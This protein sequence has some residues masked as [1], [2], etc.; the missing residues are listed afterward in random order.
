MT[1]LFSIFL[2]SPGC[3]YSISALNLWLL[4]LTRV[5]RTETKS[6]TKSDFHIFIFLRVMPFIYISGNKLFFFSRKFSNVFL[7]QQYMIKSYVFSHKL[8]ILLLSY[9]WIQ[10]MCVALPRVSKFGFSPCCQ[11]L[12]VLHEK[13][14][15]EKI[16]PQPCL[17]TDFNLLKKYS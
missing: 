10:R 2:Y 14:R 6:F 9:D 16:H 13:L 8:G 15:V 7:K 5:Q 11:A 3:W 1:G 12:L 4:E 17:L